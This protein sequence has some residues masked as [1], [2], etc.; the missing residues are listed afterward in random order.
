MKLTIGQLVDRLTIVNTKIYVQEDIKR[1][2]DATDKMIA[3]A[4]RK[5]NV[6]N[7]ERNALI[8]EIDIAMNEIAEG[9]KQ[10]LYG[11]NKSYGK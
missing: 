2:K 5:T 6:L 9:K 7:S 1:H 8:D 3:E 11:S 4:T 10:K